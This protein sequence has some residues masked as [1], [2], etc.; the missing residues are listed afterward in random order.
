MTPTMSRSKQ[1]PLAPLLS[2]ARAHG[3][4]DRAL[5]EQLGRSGADWAALTSC[6]HAT[7]SDGAAVDV[8]DWFLVAFGLHPTCIW[9]GWCEWGVSIYDA[10]PMDIEVPI[11]DLDRMPA[12]PAKAP[13]SYETLPMFAA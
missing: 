2:A 6:E 5:R 4:S 12:R 7:I 11:I 13:P 1:W 8:G 3:V 9:D 10:I